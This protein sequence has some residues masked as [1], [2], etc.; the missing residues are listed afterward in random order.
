MGCETSLPSLRRFHSWHW[1]SQA[2]QRSTQS[3]ETALKHA[4]EIIGC[5]FTC[6]DCYNFVEKSVCC[7]CKDREASNQ[8]LR[9]EQDQVQSTEDGPP[10]HNIKTK[11]ILEKRYTHKCTHIHIHTHSLYFVPPSQS[12]CFFLPPLSLYAYVGCAALDNTVSCLLRQIDLKTQQSI[13][14]CVSS[15]YT[16]RG[17]PSLMYLAVSSCTSARSSSLSME[18]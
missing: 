6:H 3:Q 1:D 4:Q 17:E 16:C 2:C 7:T 11:L 8:P 13:I 14:L 18:S 12:L 5:E 10:T 9:V 15:V